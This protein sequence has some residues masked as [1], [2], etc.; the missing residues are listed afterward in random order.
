MKLVSYSS[1]IK[2]MHGPIY[3]RMIVILTENLRGSRVQLTSLFVGTPV[4]D[5]LLL[6]GFGFQPTLSFYK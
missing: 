1:T 6:Y 3:I 2:M 4:I 5:Y